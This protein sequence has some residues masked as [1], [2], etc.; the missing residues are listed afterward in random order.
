M[1]L[2]GSVTLREDMAPPCPLS[3]LPAQQEHE[4]HSTEQDAESA[5]CGHH[6]LGHHFHVASQRI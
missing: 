5:D 3:A 2:V 1:E 4:E 6:N